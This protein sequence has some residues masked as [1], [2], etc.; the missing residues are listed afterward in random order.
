[1]KALAANKEDVTV[2]Q[3]MAQADSSKISKIL[4]GKKDQSL[5]G[6]P[7]KQ[8]MG[9]NA[10]WLM[11]K[12]YSPLCPR[13]PGAIKRPQRSPVF[14]IEKR[15]FYSAFVWARRALNRPFRR[16]SARAATNEQV[17]PDMTESV[18]R[19]YTWD[20]CRSIHA[21][22]TIVHHA[23]D[24]TRGGVCRE[25]ANDWHRVEVGQVSWKQVPCPSVCSSTWPVVARALC[26]CA[27]ASILQG[28]AALD[29]Y[30]ACAG[31]C[32]GQQMRRSCCR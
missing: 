18:V 27:P 11:F 30:Y 14:S 9:V 6:R 19:P 2:A 17:Y 20:Y 32:R 4:E 31:S 26:L 23:S 7:Q 1:M 24:S 16:V 22:N 28:I 8:S 21:S 25:T 13:P 15:F 5:D 29:T 12:V 3:V 10:I